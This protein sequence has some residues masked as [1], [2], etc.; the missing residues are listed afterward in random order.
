LLFGFA[1]VAGLARV[2]ELHVSQRRMRRRGAAGV[3]G[4]GK[5][6]ERGGK[7]RGS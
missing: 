7:A 1:Y 2:S 4:W 3:R 5:I 6:G